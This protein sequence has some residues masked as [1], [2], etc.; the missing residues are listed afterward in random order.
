M[1]RPT[2]LNKSML[3]LVQENAAVGL[4]EKYIAKLL[5]VSEETWHSW[6]RKGKA[7]LKKDK[8]DRTKNEELFIEFLEYLDSGY[9][10]VVK[11]KVVQIVTENS[12]RAS[13]EWLERFDPDTFG[14]KVPFDPEGFV[15]WMRS[16]DYP[17]WAI[18]QVLTIL[19]TAHERDPEAEE[20]KQ[21]DPAEGQ[22]NESAGSGSLGTTVEAVPSEHYSLA[23]EQRHAK[24]EAEGDDN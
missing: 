3:S 1:A 15:Q 11:D 14:K 2:K 21:N 16:R 4:P 7:A 19:E 10:S 23:P 12:W 8:K 9:A 17:V 20:H 18:D 6:K 22:P 5:K 24:L 13:L